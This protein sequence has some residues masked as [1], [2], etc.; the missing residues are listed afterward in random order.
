MTKRV[1][2]AD[3][4]ITI[5]GHLLPCHALMAGNFISFSASSPPN[6]SVSVHTSHS[7]TYKQICVV[8]SAL[9][10]PNGS[11]STIVVID[12]QLNIIHLHIESK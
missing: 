9:S 7:S 3:N 6:C 8:I 4:G 10:K 1:D 2:V 11:M 12:M 5:E